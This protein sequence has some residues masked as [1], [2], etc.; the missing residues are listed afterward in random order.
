M[1][2]TKPH[3]RLAEGPEKRRISVPAFCTEAHMSVLQWVHHF[4]RWGDG[5]QLWPKS[6]LW[7]H[8]DQGTTGIR[9]Q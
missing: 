9:H 8:S 4:L 3:G 5:A 2:N 1:V 7:V 6:T